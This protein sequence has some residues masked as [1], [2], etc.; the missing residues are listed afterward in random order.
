MV[1]NK[2]CLDL[3]AG[4]DKWFNWTHTSLLDKWSMPAEPQKAPAT[5]GLHLCRVSPACHCAGKYES[6]A[7]L[8][9][10][11]RHAESDAW[12]AMSLAFFLSVLPLTKQLVRPNG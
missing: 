5:H 7:K 8:V 9:Q 11:V 2:R 4:S 12:L 1:L 10:L 6:A 3:R